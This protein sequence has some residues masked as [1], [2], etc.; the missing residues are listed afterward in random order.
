MRYC[1]ECSVKIKGNPTDCPL[2]KNHT[3]ELPLH[4]GSL[5]NSVYFNGQKFLPKNRGLDKDPFPIVQLRYKQYTLLKVLLFVS[6]IIY[7]I[8][9]LIH[10]L[11]R[12]SGLRASYIFAGL[13][14][15]WLLVL[16]I[17]RKRRN[18]GKSILYLL[19]LISGLLVL[20]DKLTIWHGWS[21]TYAIPALIGI[22]LLAIL[23]AV[24][25]IQQELGD[26]I[27]YIGAVAIIGLVPLL[28]IILGWVYVLW[29][30]IVSISLSI[31]MLI[32]LLAFRH[33][34]IAHEIVKRMHM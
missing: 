29:P 32:Y 15:L 2:C 25:Y 14:S 1:K 23:I 12:N 27:L 16:T 26:Y 22:A 10:F 5:E 7:S 4:L 24:G 28:F 13:G 30:S 34:L 11:F 8:L 33:R 17:V 18:V 31:L 3:S 6:F 19:S 9:L 20:W 21:L